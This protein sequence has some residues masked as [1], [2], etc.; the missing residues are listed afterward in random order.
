MKNIKTITTYTK[1]GQSVEEA[2]AK[3]SLHPEGTAAALIDEFQSNLLSHESLNIDSLVAELKVINEEVFKGDIRMSIQMLNS[4]AVV[5]Q[6]IFCS[7][8]KR[9]LSQKHLPQYQTMMNL[10]LKAQSQSRATLETMARIQNPKKVIFVKQSNIAHGHQQV[11]NFSKNQNIK[12]ELLDI[13]PHE[14]KEPHER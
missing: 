6:A 7:L 11:N 14:D 2:A 8:A 5:L 12:N 1:R 3:L 10:S 13:A 4:Q 9:A